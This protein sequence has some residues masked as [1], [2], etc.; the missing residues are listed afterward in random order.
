MKILMIFICVIS[1]FTLTYAQTGGLET[2][3]QSNE[4]LPSLYIH[5]D[6]HSLYSIQ[7]NLFDLTIIPKDFY[8]TNKTNVSMYGIYSLGSILGLAILT[9]SGGHEGCGLPDLLPDSSRLRPILKTIGYVC[10]APILLSNSQ[11]YFN[12]YGFDSLTT[13][14]IG[15]SLF[16]GSQT[17]YFDRLDISWLRFAA[18][19]GL[20]LFVRLNNGLPNKNYHGPGFSIQFGITKQWDFFAHSH[21]NGSYL[22]FIGTKIYFPFNE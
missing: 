3:F 15:M 9:F 11:H 4:I 7:I 19:G 21:N 12:F 2:K 8:N 20:E 6:I 17:D 14:K 10:I 16:L 18:M 1:S 13:N 22:G 5:D